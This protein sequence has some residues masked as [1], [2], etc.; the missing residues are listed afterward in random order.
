MTEWVIQRKLRIGRASKSKSSISIWVVN[1]GGPNP[2][3]CGKFFSFFF[4]EKIKD[5]VHISDQRKGKHA[6]KKK[7]Y[8]ESLIRQKA[9]WINFSQLTLNRKLIYSYTLTN[10]NV[11]HAVENNF[12]R[13]FMQLSPK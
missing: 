1:D 8:K 7:R 11:Q 9:C 3:N 5:D 6:L 4:L 2:R 10:P 13:Y 12:S